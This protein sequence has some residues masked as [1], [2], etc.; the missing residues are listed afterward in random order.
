M[1]KPNLWAPWR[2]DYLNQLA[3][4][5]PPGTAAGG[6]FLCEAGEAGVDPQQRRDRLVLYRGEHATLLLN[7]YPYTNG[8]LLVAPHAHVAGLSDLALEARAEVMEF[9]E[10][11]GRLL[12]EVVHPQGVNVGANLGRAAGAGVPGHLHFHLVPRWT[13]DTNFMDVVGAVRVIPQALET[14]YAML[15]DGAARL[16]DEPEGVG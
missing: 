1:S 6:C 5:R 12:T 11:G 16:F 8:H 14:S 9:C 13:G 2:M 3:G 7:R 4:D 15:R 10:R